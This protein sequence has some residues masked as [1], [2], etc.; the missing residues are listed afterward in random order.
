MTMTRRLARKTIHT[1]LVF[2]AVCMFMFGLAFAVAALY[3][4]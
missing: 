1:G 2:F 4:S 3:V